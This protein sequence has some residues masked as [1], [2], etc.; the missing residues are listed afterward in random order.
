MKNCYFHL[1]RIGLVL[2][3][4]FYFSAAANGKTWHVS[5][6]NLAGIK[7]DEQVQTISKAA[8][9]AGPGDTV[10]VHDGIYRETVVIEKSGLPDSPIT[11]QA[12]TVADVVITGADRISEWTRLPG[13]D[14]IYSTPWPYKFITWN[15]NNTHPD[16]DFH[17]FPVLLRCGRGLARGAR[18]PCAEIPRL[19]REYP[20]AQLGTR[21]LARRRQAQLRRPV[22][23]PGAGRARLRFSTANGRHHA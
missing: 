21:Q 22:D 8:S 9:L 6:Q 3:T 18:G 20:R 16:D 15:R 1:L 13:E 10:I 12:A 11:F 4:G 23:G 14:R 2:M 7:Q 5:G 17:L 19:L